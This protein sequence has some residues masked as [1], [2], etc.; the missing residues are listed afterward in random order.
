MSEILSA[1]E[2]ERRESSKQLTGKLLDPLIQPE[3]YVGEVITPA[4][5]EAIVQVH[6][7][8]R[9]KVGGLPRLE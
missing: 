8:Y 4:Y 9:Q 7:H 2:E 1:L 3:N 6:D 5:D